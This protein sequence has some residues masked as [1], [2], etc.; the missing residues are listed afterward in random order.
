MPD[1]PVFICAAAQSAIVVI[2]REALEILAVRIVVI[3]GLALRRIRRIGVVHPAPSAG[4][5]PGPS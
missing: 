2:R 5:A 1:N 3:L 4:I